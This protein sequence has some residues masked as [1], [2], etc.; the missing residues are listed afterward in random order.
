MQ[1]HGAGQSQAVQSG[2]HIFT[3][4]FGIYYCRQHII[5][6]VPDLLLGSDK[7]TA[8]LRCEN[9]WAV[10]MASNAHYSTMLA[11]LL[12]QLFD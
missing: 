1:K 8:F 10:L 2:R 9:I 4:L 12:N 3:P 6:L 11:A 7:K 5:L